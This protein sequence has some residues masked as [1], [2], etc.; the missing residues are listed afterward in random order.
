MQETQKKTYKRRGRKPKLF[1]TL[2]NEFCRI[3]KCSLRTKYGSLGSFVNVF[4]PCTRGDLHNVVLADLCSAAGI[5]LQ[6][7]DELS[8]LV[9]PT[10]FRRTYSFCKLTHSVAAELN[11]PRKKKRKPWTKSKFKL[12]NVSLFCHRERVLCE[13]CGDLTITIPQVQNKQGLQKHA[14]VFLVI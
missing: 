11:K 8:T 14:V 5:Q 4:K 2:V 9:C 13:N 12:Q 10:C 1:N 6:E 3:C 7:N